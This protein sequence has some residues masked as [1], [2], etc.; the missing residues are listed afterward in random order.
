MRGRAAAEIED[1]SEEWTEC[2]DTGYDDADGVFSVA[3]EYDV[4]YAVCKNILASDV[5]GRS[6]V[7]S[8]RYSSVLVKFT[9]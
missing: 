6:A 3:P 1:V 8:Q 5:R 7:D 2:G 9:V 4:G